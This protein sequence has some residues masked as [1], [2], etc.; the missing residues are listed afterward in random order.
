MYF[1]L[2]SLHQLR[3]NKELYTCRL[4]LNL[5]VYSGCPLAAHV[6]HC[7]EEEVCRRYS[8]SSASSSGGLVQNTTTP[9][10]PSFSWQPSTSWSGGRG[11][12]VECGGRSNVVCR[13]RGCEGVCTPTFLD[14][15]TGHQLTCQGNSCTLNWLLSIEFE[16]Y[17]RHNV[18]QGLARLLPNPAKPQHSL[19]IK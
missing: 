6:V 14:G 16:V 19:A 13:A 4:C 17:Q 1:I 7:D 3:V 10:L 15:L 8:S 9:L 18:H 2:V 11:G 12:R 5:R